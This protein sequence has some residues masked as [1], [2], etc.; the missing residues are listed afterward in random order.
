MEN[1]TVVAIIVG[2]HDTIKGHFFP[3]DSSA[4]RQFSLF[5]QDFTLMSFLMHC[6]EYLSP[7]LHALLFIDFVIP[8]LKHSVH[9]FIHPLLILLVVRDFILLCPLTEDKFKPHTN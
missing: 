4:M 7:V 2:M 3:L 5:A 1:C 6:V 8:L 9:T